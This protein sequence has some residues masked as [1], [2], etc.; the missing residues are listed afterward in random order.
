MSMDFINRYYSENPEEDI[1]INLKHYSFP[2]NIYN[3]YEKKDI[4]PSR[5]LVEVISG[6]FIQAFEYFKASEK[7]TIQTSPLLLYY[8]TTNLLYGASC[9]IEGEIKEVNGHGINLIN[10]NKL[11]ENI[12]E[13][14][15][16][17]E[18]HKTG[19]FRVYLNS[20]TEQ[21]INSSLEWTILELLGSIPEIYREF[22]EMFDRDLLYLIP[23]EKI[24]A[25]YET[26]FKSN[27]NVLSSHDIQEKLKNIKYYNENYLRT[28]ESN[29][30]S[31]IF[32][33]K[34]N[35]TSLVKQ[36]YF[37]E[38]YFPVAHM[39]KNK[40]INYDPFIY[41]YMILYS[42]GTLCRY[43]PSVWNP[44]VRLDASGEVNL[45]EKFLVTVR[46]YFPNYILDKIKGKK[47]FYSNQLYMPIDIKKK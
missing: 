10:K 40:L 7:T 32:S 34:I 31:I 30:G 36:S 23:L 9:L 42:L 25:D 45:I 13:N 37:G 6:S 5:E 33:L 14:K 43:H 2:K 38:Y 18:S 22:I 19:G 12:L 46:R 20:L 1:W 15:I 26:N 17:I 24:I 16:K 28:R 29:D 4:K 41:Q 3:F 44:F 21:N 27:L 8:G 35:G 11:N 47:H 39:K